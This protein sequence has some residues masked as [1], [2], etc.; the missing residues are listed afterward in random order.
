MNEEVVIPWRRVNTCLGHMCSVFACLTRGLK[1]TESKILVGGVWAGKQK[2]NYMPV[3]DI[4]KGPL[5][6]KEA[7]VP[8][9]GESVSA[10]YSY[11]SSSLRSYSQVSSK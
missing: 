8:A 1:E 10:F 2:R 5:E 3:R 7:F 9:L 4:H 11:L 6:T